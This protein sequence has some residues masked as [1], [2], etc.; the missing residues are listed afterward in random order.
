MALNTQDASPPQT[1]F[2][3]A[4]GG[5][6]LQT[7]EP[8][9]HVGMQYRSSFQLLLHLFTRIQTRLRRHVLQ[10]AGD[11][12]ASDDEDENED[13]EEEVLFANCMSRTSG[14][15]PDLQERPDRQ[16][17]N[18]KQLRNSRRFELTQWQNGSRVRCVE[19]SP[20]QPAT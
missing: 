11:A 6:R 5:A 3:I 13:G 9:A 1:A 15:P 8:C 2:E 14:S 4:S 20:K 16:S 17:D 18:S 12:D 19:L 10:L 7:Q